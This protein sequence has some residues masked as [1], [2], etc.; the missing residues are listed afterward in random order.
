MD[1]R[2]A[3]QGDAVGDVEEGFIEGKPLHQGCHLV[4]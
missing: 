3:E 4:K 1:N 2:I